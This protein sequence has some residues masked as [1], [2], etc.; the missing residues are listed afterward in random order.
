MLMI[1][2]ITGAAVA[3]FQSTRI[4]RF[5][6]RNYADLARAQM[7]AEAG[8]AAGQATLLHAVTNTRGGTNQWN[9]VSGHLVSN[10]LISALASNAEANAFAFVGHV[11]PVNGT[12]T[13]TIFLA[14]T[15]GAGLVTWIP[16]GQTPA[17]PRYPA[18]WTNLVVTNATGAVTTNA[19]YAFWISDDTCK[20]NLRAAGS[21]PVRGFLTDPAGIALMARTRANS[22]ANQRLPASDVARFSTNEIQLVPGISA[23]NTGWNSNSLGRKNS[24]LMT[25]ATIQALF[26]MAGLSP[27]PEHSLENDLARET[28]SAPL[29]P[30][31]RPR[32]NLT[33]LASFL[34]ALALNQGPASPRA[35]AVR[36]ILDATATNY[37][38]NWGGG[39]LAFLLN[40]AVMGGK[41][42]V[43]EAR[44]FVANIFDAIDSDKIPT[45]DWNIDNSSA[46]PTFLGTEFWMDTGKPQGHPFMVYVAGG[47]WASAVSCRSHLAVGF[48]NPWPEATEPWATKYRLDPIE[49][50]PNFPQFPKTLTED[51]TGGN[52]LDAMPLSSR[53]K[54][55]NGGI[56]RQGG[57]L[58]PCQIDAGGQN[59]GIG[60]HYSAIATGVQNTNA[61][62]L[63]FAINKINLFYISTEGDYL[64]ARLPIPANPLIVA[65]A[66]AANSINNLAYAANRQ[67]LW[68][69][70]DPRLGSLSSWHWTTRNN[71]PSGSG[72]GIIPSSQG[73]GLGGS[74]FL[75]IITATGTDGLQNLNPTLVNSD[76]N[77]IWFRDRDITN[78]FNMDGSIELDKSKNVN[79]LKGLG[80]LGFINAGKPWRT[81]SFNA[82]NNPVGQ[83]DWKIA[84][85]VYSGDE[86][87][88]SNEIAHVD[89]RSGVFARGGTLATRPGLF[90]RDASVNVHS[91]NW[92]TWR[93]LLEGVPLPAGVSAAGVAAAMVAHAPT[94][95][96]SNTLG[97]LTN[98]NIALAWF[99]TPSNN[100]F[101]RE[102]VYRYLADAL[103]IRSRNFT[104]YAMGETLSTNAAGGLRPIARSLMLSRVRF[105]VNTNTNP[106]TGGGVT[107]E[108]LET[109]PY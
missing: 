5:V 98:T 84:D 22:A 74:S 108:V 12:V 17:D 47:Y 32:L 83:E 58:F 105:G 82:S 25:P 87:N 28:L 34:N 65:S 68:L 99:G 53:I 94:N 69:T 80:F 67:A 109:K 101:A 6:S 54:E 4:E 15:S 72:L 50:T 2:V 14:S 75:N 71:G 1:T 64:V 19:R 78:H 10:P 70:N 91:A 107:L 81:V 56:I 20:L 21:A 51:G 60:P 85:Y 8:L 103:T 90:S 61:G 102:Q 43:N 104:I 52:S 3:F 39:D 30:N 89:M 59:P 62:Q 40:P 79:Q 55:T 66:F 33:R 31:G 76:D 88:A 7:A 11:N 23:T 48:A 86:L 9:Y 95:P 38:A 46:D 45:T 96:Y 29:A 35:E 44:Q 57:G 37:H 93:S 41:W 106:A 13:N 18:H 42:T 27:V 26:P 92:N 97:F 49:I 36:N 73:G 77:T 24:A 63:T 100:D 16:L